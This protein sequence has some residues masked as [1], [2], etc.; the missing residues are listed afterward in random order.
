MTS[1]SKTKGNYGELIA[2]YYLLQNK[3]Q[4]LTT[5][6]YSYHGEIDIIAEDPKRDQLVFIEV[7]NYKKN[8][9]LAPIQAV[10]KK[11]MKNI[12]KTA[13]YYLSKFGEKNFRFDLIG[14]EENRVKTHFRNFLRL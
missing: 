9:L 14:I 6:F 10:T 1:F 11:K 8:S 5:N 7:K 4:I 13:Y 2:Q 12:L 3:Y